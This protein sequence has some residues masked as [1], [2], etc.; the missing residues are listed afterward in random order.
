MNVPPLV[1]SALARTVTARNIIECKNLR[2]EERTVQTLQVVTHPFLASA[3]KA[4]RTGLLQPA[5]AIMT[6]CSGGVYIYQIRMAVC[7]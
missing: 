4:M 2:N 7:I 1:P 5:T 6:R 3:A